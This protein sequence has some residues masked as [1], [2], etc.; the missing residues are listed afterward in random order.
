MCFPTKL[1]YVSVR[2]GAA[3]GILSI[4]LIVKIRSN[5]SENYA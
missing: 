3:K 4:L 1:N 2:E 5:C